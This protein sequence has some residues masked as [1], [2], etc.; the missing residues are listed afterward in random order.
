ML[1]IDGVYVYIQN[2][3]VILFISK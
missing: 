1:E 3:N 2:R